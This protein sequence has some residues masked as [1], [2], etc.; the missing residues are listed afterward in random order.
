MRN[1]FLLAIVFKLLRALAEEV[2]ADHQPHQHQ[3]EHGKA[4][5]NPP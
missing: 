1:S 5:Q 4:A 2:P 3:R